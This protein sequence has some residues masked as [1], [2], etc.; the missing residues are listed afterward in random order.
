[1]VPVTYV[2]QLRC[3]TDTA[4]FYVDHRLPVFPD[5][6]TVVALKDET[7]GTFQ[8]LFG[9]SPGEMYVSL[10]YAGGETADEEEWEEV[11]DAD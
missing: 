3:S 2:L 10:T 8:A 7:E 6:A 1:M 5:V 11:P 4:E 9:E